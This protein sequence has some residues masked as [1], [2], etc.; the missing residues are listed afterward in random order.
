[1]G[2]GLPKLFIEAEYKWYVLP[3]VLSIFLI[4]VPC[5]IFNWSN[6]NRSLDSNGIN[7]R[8]YRT[9]FMTMET[10]TNKYT[11]VAFLASYVELF[12]HPLIQPITR[13][14][15]QL[16]EAELLRNPDARRPVMEHFNDR[17]LQAYWEIY[18]YCSGIGEFSHPELREVVEG[19]LEI[20][21][22]A[23]LPFANRGMDG[24]VLLGNPDWTL[25]YIGMDILY[26]VCRFSRDYYNR[27]LAFPAKHL[28][29]HHLSLSPE[30]RTRALQLPLDPLP[31][32]L[33]SKEKLEQLVGQFEERKRD[34]LRRELGELPVYSC[35]VKTEVD[36]KQVKVVTAYDYVDIKYQLSR[37]PGSGFCAL[38][39]YAYPKGETIYLL[40]S[41]EGSLI[42]FQKVSL[43]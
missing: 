11:C 6:R 17:Q 23:V 2:I 8:G 30:E 29:L 33:Q 31:A 38:S 22:K 15:R 12:E 24:V 14:D 13:E 40:M 32:I 27:S 7:V 3:L 36:G 9:L 37:Q 41:S 20:S 16:L 39:N 25:R 28:W 5:F 35:M 1:V 21:F 4:V 43:L 34:T 19:L 18:R 10:P 26:G 42:L